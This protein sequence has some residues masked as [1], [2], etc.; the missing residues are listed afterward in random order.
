MNRLWVRQSLAFVL[1]I[2]FTVLLVA[3]LANARASSSFRRYLMHQHGLEQ[4][5]EEAGHQGMRGGQMQGGGTGT[6]AGNQGAGGMMQP[7]DQAFLNDLRRT[8]ILASIVAGA[9]GILAGVL[10]SRTVSAPL[11]RLASAARDFAAHRWDRRVPVSGSA[12]IAEVAGAFNAMADELQRAETLRRNLMADIAHELRTPL[13]VMQSSLRALLDGVYPLE[14]REIASVYDETRLLSRLV[15]D[16]R[17]LALAEAGAPDVN[18]QTVV[19]QSFLEGAVDQF[20]LVADAQNTRIDLQ[21]PPDVAFVKADPDRLSQVIH[22]LLANALRHTPDGT[23][24]I[25]LDAQAANIRISVSDTGEG[26]PSEA[27]P[28]VFDRFYRAGS[29]NGDSRAHG[30]S[31]LGLAIAKAWVEAMHGEIGVASTVGQGSVFWFTL[32]AASPL[33]VPQKAKPAA[34]PA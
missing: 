12:E 29:S 7:G 8:L 4:E 14:L 21:L 26:I 19:V 3:A 30:S 9:I 10:I 13:A 24:T 22:N 34:L 17:E 31:G 33:E 23:V 16:L 25:S 20:A 6:G 2:L 32:T 5:T 28:A 27:L 11:G 1:V 15:A 18:I